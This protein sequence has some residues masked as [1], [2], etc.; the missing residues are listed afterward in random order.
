MVHAVSSQPTRGHHA[1]ALFH[2]LDAH[3]P[4][5]PFD[6][7]MALPPSLLPSS[8]DI[9]DEDVVVSLFFVLKTPSGN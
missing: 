7:L 4:Y 3:H 8:L 2:S 1:S 5:P 9:P 6:A